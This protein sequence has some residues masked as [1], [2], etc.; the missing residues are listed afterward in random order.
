MS[1][2]ETVLDFIDTWRQN[3]QRLHAELGSLANET[4]RLPDNFHYLVSE[5]GL[6]DPETGGFIKEIIDRISPLGL[7]EFKFLETLESWANESQSMTPLRCSLSTPGTS[8]NFL[9]SG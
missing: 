3:P 4:H 9:N 8:G 5:D 6:R 2:K 1:N 7:S